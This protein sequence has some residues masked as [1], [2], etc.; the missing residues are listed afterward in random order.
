MIFG[1]A[2]YETKE[3]EEVTRKDRV[4]A[5]TEAFSRLSEFLSLHP[6]HPAG[7]WDT[8]EAS[9]RPA[10]KDP[11]TEEDLRARWLFAFRPATGWP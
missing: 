9:W 8:V 4:E 11:L 3:G 1:V 10:D 2:I 6:E 7:K 5:Q